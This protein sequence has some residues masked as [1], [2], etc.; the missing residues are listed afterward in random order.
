MHLFFR[1]RLDGANRMQVLLGN[2]RLKVF[3]LIELR[4]L[5]GGQWHKKTLDFSKLSRNE[6]GSGGKLR[7]GDRID[8]ILFFVPRNTQ[9][10]VDDV[11]LY[12]PDDSKKS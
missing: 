12:E 1:Y 6:D 5:A 10:L 11:L 9:L 3:H 8:E 2:R 7:K 4:D